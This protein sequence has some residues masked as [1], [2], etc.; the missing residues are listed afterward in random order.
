MS[1]KRGICLMVFNE[2]QRVLYNRYPPSLFFHSP[3][4]LLVRFDEIPFNEFRI[5]STARLNKCFVLT[6]YASMHARS[7][8]TY[9]LLSLAWL[10][11]YL[12]YLLVLKKTNIVQFLF[13]SQRAYRILQNTSGGLWSVF[14][15]G[16]LC[17]FQN[18]LSNIFV[19]HPSS[20]Y[21]SL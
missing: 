18:I 15:G 8:W 21:L 10:I 12:F 2:F 11:A 13:V 3:S 14:L 7:N 4:A 6:Q 5:W 1:D 16:V 20:S 19:N 17:F 9:I